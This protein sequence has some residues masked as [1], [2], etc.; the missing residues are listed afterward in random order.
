[1]VLQDLSEDKLEDP[2][3]L[4]ILVVIVSM[5]RSLVRGRSGMMTVLVVPLE[6]PLRVE[7]VHPQEVLEGRAGLQALDSVVERGKVV[8]V[9]VPVVRVRDSGVLCRRS[10]MSARRSS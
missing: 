4:L 5:V 9:V 3:L 2:L 10:T 8:V 1:M 7:I 6:Q